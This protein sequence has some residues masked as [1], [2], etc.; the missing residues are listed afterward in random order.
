MRERLAQVGSPLGADV[1]C[2]TWL[3]DWRPGQDVSEG[4][5]ASPQE[6]GVLRDLIHEIDYTRWLLGPQTAGTARLENRRIL[7]FPDAV[8]ESVYAIVQHGETT[9]TMRLSYVVRPP[10]RRLRIWCRE[11]LLLWDGIARTAQLQAPSGEVKAS[12][13][14]DGPAPMYQKQAEAWVAVLRGERPSPLMVDATEG[15]AELRVC[16]ALRTSATTGA[17]ESPS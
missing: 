11:G 17:W 3:P 10:T 6:G 9:L 15:A 7:G 14:W 16:D 1:E 4:Y 2:L 12:F 13:A 5:A 8:E